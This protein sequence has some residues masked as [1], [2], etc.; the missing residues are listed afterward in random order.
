MITTR[1]SR[2]VWASASV[3]APGIGSARSKLAWSSIWQ[4][5]WLRNSSG[6]QTSFAPRSAPSTM[7][8]RARARLSCGSAE[9]RI[10]TRP[11]LNVFG[12]ATVRL[13]L[14]EGDDVAEQ[15]IPD[16]ARVVVEAFG[17]GEDA[18]AAFGTQRAPHVIGVLAHPE[19]DG[20]AL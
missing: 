15:A 20:F 4:K 1:L 6:R 17:V 3:V 8:A 18:R 5:Y 13:L 7:R 19:R 16:R 11:I 14:H 10:C 9:Q 12:A 2:A